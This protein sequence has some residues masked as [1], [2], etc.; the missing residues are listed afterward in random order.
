MITAIVVVNP[1]KLEIMKIVHKK[2]AFFFLTLTLST[3]GIFA[4]CR[5]ISVN[6]MTS[7]LKNL[8]EPT[9][10]I[11][12]DK[13]NA[14]F[15]ILGRTERFS[16]PAE[17]ISKPARDWRYHVQDVRSMDSNLWFDKNQKNFVLDVKFEGDRE[18]IKGTC[19]G[20][21]KA[22]RDRRAPDVNWGGARIARLRFVPVPF[23]GSVSIQVLNVELFGDFDV[24]GPLESFFPVMIRNIENRIKSDIQTRG[25]NLLNNIVI[26]RRISSEIRPLIAALGINSVR[27]VQFSR[28]GTKIQFCN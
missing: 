22:F 1:L 4:Q 3:L 8:I 2:T 9:I 24:N 13:D 27:R 5:E 23:E 6:S 15:A 25:R 17:N 19:P 20:C 11:T 26:Q 12:L 21:L 18:E 28:D 16:I 10:G 14:S 7:T